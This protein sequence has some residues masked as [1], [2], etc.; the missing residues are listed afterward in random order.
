[1]STPLQDNLE[2]RRILSEH[3]PEIASG[4]V[5]IKGIAREAGQRSIVAVHA[6]DARVCPVGSCVGRRG[7]I[8][9]S[10]M[11]A[12]PGDKIDIVRWS[13]SLH[14]FVR[15]LLAPA[16]VEHISFD[17]AAHFATVKVSAGSAERL[18]G[19]GGVKL[20]LASRLVGWDLRVNET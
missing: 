12:L 4:A 16:K 6:S 17:T 18:T 13:E 5:E 2:L 9:K 11:R 7:E 19:D 20:R 10:V 15:N 14:D 1:M 3:V 8:V